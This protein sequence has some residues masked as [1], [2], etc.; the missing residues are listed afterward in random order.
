VLNNFS[1]GTNTLAIGYNTG[2]ASVPLSTGAFDILNSLS[3]GYGGSVIH[4]VATTRVDG[5]SGGGLLVNGQLTVNAGL[6]MVTNSYTAIGD[7]GY[8]SLT[9]NGGTMLVRDIVLGNVS[10]SYGM[11]MISSG[12]LQAFG[13][14]TVA[15]GGAYAPADGQLSL[16]GGQLVTTNS[17]VNIG[18]NDGPGIPGN[19]LITVS[20]GNWLAKDVNV[21]YGSSAIGTLI[22]AGG[23]NVLSGTLSLANNFYSD[24]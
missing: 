22:I 8:G 18:D 15:T 16:N 13:M 6:L 1:G 14:L 20:N 11:L 23:T 9:I 21:G 5:I 4:G 7:I 2:L 19:G 17:A 24:S 12:K 10:G 3:I